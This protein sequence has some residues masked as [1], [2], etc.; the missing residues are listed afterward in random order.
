MCYGSKSKK[1]GSI[2]GKLGDVNMIGNY[3]STSDF[4]TQDMYFWVLDKL[5]NDITYRFQENV[6]YLQSVRERTVFRIG[7][8]LT[9]VWK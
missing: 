1:K 9:Y 4:Y 6:C 7:C 2:C 5:I 3:I 8:I